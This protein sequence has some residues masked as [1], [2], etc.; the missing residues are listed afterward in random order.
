MFNYNFIN[1]I[2]YNSYTFIYI[3]FVEVVL[4]LCHITSNYIVLCSIYYSFIVY[5]FIYC[6]YTPIVQISLTNRKS[7]PEK[8]QWPLQ[9]SAATISPS[10]AL[11]R[12]PS[13]DTHWTVNQFGKTRPLNRNWTLPT[14]MTH[15]RIPCS[16]LKSRL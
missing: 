1:Y 6:K 9:I 3:L 16:L 14:V 4:I 11:Q 10:F 7:V 5:P 8:N 2:N 15:A 13:L 12:W